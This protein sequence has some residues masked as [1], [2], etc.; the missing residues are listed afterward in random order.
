M[1]KKIRNCLMME[2][3]RR[4]KPSSRCLQISYTSF[5]INPLMKKNNVFPK[6]NTKILFFQS[7]A[8]IALR[9]RQCLSKKMQF[10]FKKSL[11]SKQI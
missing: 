3:K 7:I 8:A 2:K 5:I 1:Q 11:L 9:K 4:I 6:K 10:F